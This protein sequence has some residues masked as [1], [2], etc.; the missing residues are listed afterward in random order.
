MTRKRLPSV[1]ICY[2][3]EEA[4]FPAFVLRSALAQHWGGANV[5]I[6]KSIRPGEKFPEELD[7]QIIGADFFLAVIGPHWL[8]PRL[9]DPDDWVR[10]EIRTA[11]T[12][13]T[14]VVP[15][16]VDDALM[17]AERQIPEDIRFLSSMMAHELTHASWQADVDELAKHLEAQM[18]PLPSAWLSWSEVGA[19]SMNSRR[20]AIVPEPLLVGGGLALA[21]VITGEPAMFG[22]AGAALATLTA[23]NVFDRRRSLARKIRQGGDHARREPS[24][25]S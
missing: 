1:F 17:P 25:Q 11:G 24:I 14:P 23:V 13:G 6:D 3:R 4:S 18:P 2:R 22:V 5:F 12:S 9:S 10:R 8:T 19:L 20:R 7:R 15:I 21:A 16:L